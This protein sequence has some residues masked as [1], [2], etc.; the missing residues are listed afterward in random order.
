MFSPVIPF[1]EYGEMWH[2]N[3]TN[4]KKQNVFD[5]FQAAAEYISLRK[6]TPPPTSEI[7]KYYTV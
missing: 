4:G 6:S 1:S 3:G 2:E 5:D 7:V